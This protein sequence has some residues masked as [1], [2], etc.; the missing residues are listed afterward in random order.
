MQALSFQQP[1]R[2]S[3]T[4]TT[5]DNNAHAHTISKTI[6][7]WEETH[8]RSTTS[9]KK[10]YAQITSVSQTSASTKCHIF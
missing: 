1:Y 3:H 5:A 2:Q 4:G 9:H 10:V 7:T 6:T 8:G